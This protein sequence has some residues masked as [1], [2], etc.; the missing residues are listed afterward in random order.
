MQARS[1]SG[2]LGAI[3]QHFA[4]LIER[5]GFEVAQ[6]TDVP[7]FAWFRSGERLVIVSYDAADDASV[8]VHFEVKSTDERHL[9][10]DILAFERFDARRRENVRGQANIEAEIAR[11]AALLGEHCIDFL[12]GDLEAFRRRYREALLV[13][14]TR[15]AAMREFYDG[16]PKRSKTLFEALRAY[17]TD[18]DREHVS[19]LATGSQDKSLAHLRLKM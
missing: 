10:A 13:K 2:T 11:A 19:R 15:A 14:T 17:W 6:S 3:E 8:D 7:S 4:F 12:T 9:L 5:Y 16:D 1:G 18:L